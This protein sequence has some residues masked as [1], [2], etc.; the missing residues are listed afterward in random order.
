MNIRKIM[1]MTKDE[2]LSIPEKDLPLA[3]LSSSAANIFAFGIINIRKSIYNH[4]M[5]M[6]KPGFFASQDLFYSEVP[7]EKYLKF[8]NRLKFWYNPNWEIYEKEAIK[9]EIQR[10]LNKPKFS[11]RYDWMAI[12][13][14]ALNLV[15][16]QNPITRICSDYGS[17]LR[18]SGVD[19][20]YNLKNPAPDQVDNW[21]SKN[22]K[23]NIYGRYAGE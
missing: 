21:F 12:L 17:I 8:D 20:E 22:I 23:Y 2:V 1:Y 16:I 11:T 5:W 18:E 9:H 14:Q 19:P 6:H 13:G 3:V 15:W 10:W 7:A 4:F